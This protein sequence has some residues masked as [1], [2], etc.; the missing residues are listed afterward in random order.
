M[1][2]RKELRMKAAAVM[3]MLSLRNFKTE[4]YTRSLTVGGLV[5]VS[6]HLAVVLRGLA[7][8]YIHTH[9]H[10]LI[11][12]SIHPSIYPSTCPSVYLSIYPSIHLPSICLSVYLS[13]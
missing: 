4:S 2:G 13:I 8:I 10:M 11:C 5:A 9:V 3:H 12:L 1:K 6:R 7:Y